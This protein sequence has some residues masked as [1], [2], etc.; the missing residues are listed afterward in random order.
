M[1]QKLPPLNALKCFEI[2]ARELSFK[3]AAL[4]LSLTPAAVGYHIRRLE[5][6][7]GKKLFHRLNR[8]LALTDEG[9]AYVAVVQEAFNILAKGTKMLS[10][11]KSSRHVV[12]RVTWSLSSKWLVTRLEEFHRRYPHLTVQ[13]DSSDEATDFTNTEIDIALQYRNNIDQSLNSVLLFAE[14]VF[15][16]CSPELVQGKHPIRSANDLRH[17]VLLHDTMTDLS[18]SDWLSAINA[19]D[20][21]PSIGPIMSHSSLTVD[22]AIA[23]EGIALG[24]SPLVTDDLVAG[25]LVRPFD[26]S[27]VSNWGYHVVCLPD[28]ASELKIQAFSD[29]VLK[30]AKTSEAIMLLRT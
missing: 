23:G 27:L 9:K 10:S 12:V 30:E 24:R 11:G 29:W 19:V 25:R 28:R 4:E 13:L 15:P 1:S 3:K 18:W 20:V 2:A 21:N 22:A 5:A 14:Q 17:H 16:V 6:D 8:A 7:L 26:T